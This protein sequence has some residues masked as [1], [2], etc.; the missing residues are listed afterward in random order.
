[1]TTVERWEKAATASL[2]GKTVARVRYMTREEVSEMDWYGAA[3]V[4]EFTDGSWLL[5]S[6]DDEGNGAG[7]LFSSDKN[8]EVIPVITR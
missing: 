2:K 8:L 5:A 6:S 7:A 1:M 3:P 4:I